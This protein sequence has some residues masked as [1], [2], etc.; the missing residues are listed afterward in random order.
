MTTERHEDGQITTELLEGGVLAICIDR[1]EKRNGF[2]PKMMLELAEAY[3]ALEENGDARVGLLHAAGG[4][5]TGGL[6]LPKIVAAQKAGDTLFPSGLVDPL[7]LHGR[8]VS[9]P[10]VVATAGICFTIG[11]E[12]IL[13]ADVAVAASNSRFSQLEVKRGIMAY[14]GATIRMVERAGWGNAMKLIL[15]G[16][17]FD[18]ETARAY[19]FIQ[20]IV[21]PG[22][23]FDA[24]LA[25]AR[26]IAVQAPLAVQA[27]LANARLAVLKGPQAAVDAFGEVTAMLAASED[28]AEGVASF[29]EKRPPVY[30]GK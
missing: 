23:E 25:I 13:A 28:A 20:D 6:D 8:R 12:L 3:T 11:I 15:T 27:S 24:A 14:G 19:G 9:K 21:A 29:R 22:E 1:A 5:F 26:R 10:V 7:G 18:V 16:D 30:R 4:H 17:E 2:T